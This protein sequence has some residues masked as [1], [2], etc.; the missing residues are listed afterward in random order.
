DELVADR[1][2][3][4]VGPEGRLLELGVGTGRIALP[5][6]RRGR[7]IV[8]LD[9]SLPMLDR[10]RAKA[11]ALG[12]PPP[13]VLRADATRLPF[14]D[15]CVDAVLEVHVLHLIPDWR[16][17]LAEARRV[18]R[19]GGMVLVGRG[20]RPHG[21]GPRERVRRRFEQLATEVGG[22]HRDLVGVEEDADKVAELV[23]LGGVPEE[24]EPVAWEE[25]ETHAQA[26]ATMEGRVFSWQWR[27]P[28]EVWREA[29]TRLRAEVE[30]TVGDLD[31]PHRSRHSFKLTAVRF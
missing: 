10:Y 2:D 18:L 6:H 1:I 14:R 3:A 15:A 12:L 16:Q 23:A 25:Q 19:P 4:A 17:A 28:D 11:A 31:A 13:A 29:I 26:L 30:D 7:R 22:G 27:L 20:G 21:D 9:L 24:L 8:G 5:L